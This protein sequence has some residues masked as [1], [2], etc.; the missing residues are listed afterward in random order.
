MAF[1]FGSRMVGNV[2]LSNY[3]RETVQYF[4]V[5]ELQSDPK[6]FSSNFGFTANERSALKIYQDRFHFQL[7]MHAP[8]SNIN[9][10]ALSN[11]ERQLGMR[12]FENTIQIS[13]DLGIKLITFHPI[14]LVPGMTP[15]QY[16]EACLLE[17][18]SI[19]QLLKEARK[20]GVALL[21]E[22]M[23]AL[24]EYPPCTRDGARFQELLWL[25]PE[26]EFGLTI[27]VG[28]ALQAG[29]NTD[30]LLKMERIRHFHFHDNNRIEDLHQ[31]IL[32]DLAWWGKLIKGLAKRFPDAAAILEITSL[33]EQLDSYKN[34]AKFLPKQG[35]HGKK[36]ELMI[37]PILP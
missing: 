1:C 11:E 29:I 13:A 24:S 5:I 20:S 9:L 4:P 30:A 7:T 15:E 31:P 25:F 28:H 3:L 32:Q 27:D 16:R 22:N 26:P 19:A 34:L 8:Y 33:N 18:D 37:P 35:G 6:F 2:P 17:E 21:M 12:I 23:P 14:P 10:G 36:R